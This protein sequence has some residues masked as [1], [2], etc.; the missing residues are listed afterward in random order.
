MRKS[1]NRFNIIAALLVCSMIGLLS[2]KN[3]HTTQRDYVSISKY[4]DE[5][6]LEVKISGKGGH[7]EKCLTFE[8]KNKTPDSLFIRLEPGGRIVCEDSSL[9]DIL[10]VKE[11]LMALAPNSKVTAEGY[12]FCCRATKH[13]PSKNSKFNIGFMSP[14]KWVELAEVINQNNF[15]TQP[16][17]NAIWVLSDNHPITSIYYEKMEEIDL[18]LQTVEKIKG[19]KRPWYSITY[20]K[21][22]SML[23]S[24]RPET[25]H[26]KINYYTNKNTVISINVRSAKGRL[27]TTLINEELK[28]TGNHEYKLNFDI[29]NWPKGD[30]D[31][32]VFEDY[33][34]LNF[35]KRFTI[36]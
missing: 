17:Q 3:I 31:V 32:N 1:I 6:K 36:E 30:Y 35:K 4:I 9:Q 18:L 28:N 12:G 29:T 34:N 24:N 14:P 8:L 19:I 27:M 25:L 13:S 15:P 16:I 33:S 7:S 23:F 20:A 2:L 26:G 22:T 21:D 10:I 5:H 11:N